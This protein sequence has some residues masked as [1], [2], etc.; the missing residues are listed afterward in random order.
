[1]QQLVRAGV[2]E[3]RLWGGD[4]PVLTPCECHVQRELVV[5]KGC[6]TTR[7]SYTQPCQCP[8]RTKLSIDSTQPPELPRCPT[9]GA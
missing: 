8:Q 5:M 2:Y 1:M 6:A 9:R 4:E 3:F 7:A